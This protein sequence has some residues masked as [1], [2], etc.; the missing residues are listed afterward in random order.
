M[1]IK[2]F[3]N[4]IV[5][6][7]IGITLFVAC[8][9]PA[10]G[11]APA[12]KP[13]IKVGVI[14]A[15][16]GV[17][18]GAGGPEKEG[19]VWAAEKIN[20][21]GGINGQKIELVIEDDEGNETNTASLARKLATVNNVSAIIG[22]TSIASTKVLGK[23]AEELKVPY[24]A[25]MY[26]DLFINNG[27]RYSFSPWG[28]YND[29]YTWYYQYLLKGQGWKKKVVILH[30]ATSSGQLAAKIAKDVL[31]PAGIEVVAEQ[32]QV[33][34]LEFASTW[35]KI[36][37]ARPDGVFL[38]GGT[39][40]APAA[41]MKA[42]MET[43]NGNITVVA[44]P[45]VATK[46]LVDLASPAALEG[47]VVVGSYFAFDPK[48]QPPAEK[49]L[50]DII[51]KSQGTGNYPAVYHGVTWDAMQIL[52]KAMETAGGDREKIVTAIH[53]IKNSTLALGTHNFGPGDT[54]ADHT[55][56]RVKDLKILKF[57]SGAF[58]QVPYTP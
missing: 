50:F 9:K 24:L 56:L 35:V 38:Y 20:S 23:T 47:L 16:T 42:R 5:V 25:S 32:Y 41:I 21:K 46:M 10:Q 14:V 12:T 34:D 57:E 18:A 52:A 22:G 36:K 37:N 43:G 4:Y 3:L 29:E 48:T 33:T 51:A 53:G 54:M 39:V 31:G 15:A 40:P 27:D 11:P 6:A 45:S 55:S 13:P 1:K 49:E 19:V 7:V 8:S 26:G 28:L 58:R 30:D 44:V 2:A 17:R